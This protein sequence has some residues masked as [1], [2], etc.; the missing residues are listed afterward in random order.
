[1]MCVVLLSMTPR[2]VAPQGGARLVHGVV[3]DTTGQ[4]L[5]DARVAAIGSAFTATTDARG[6]FILNAPRTGN[7]ELQIRKIGFLGLTRPLRPDEG[8]Q[9]DPIRLTLHATPLPLAGLVI[10]G[11]R[12]VPLG[13]TVT[14]QS[15]RQ[16]PPLG[17]PDVM[18]ALPFVAG[19]SQPNDL[20]N[21]LHFAG[22]SADE[23]L[24]LLDGHPIQSL[25]HLSGVIGGFNVA[26]VDRAELLLHHVPVTTPSR[27]GGTLLLETRER[28]AIGGEAVASM[29]SS[30]VTTST[31]HRGVDVLASGRLTYLDALSRRL[32]G[33]TSAARDP[34][35]SYGDAMI[36]LGGELAEG[37]AELLSYFSRDWIGQRERGGARA[38]S[39][40]EGLVGARFVRERQHSRLSAR[41]SLDRMLVARASATVD[42]ADA[43]AL[44]QHWA[45]A[46]ITY[47]R[48]LTGALA[49][50]SLMGADSRVHRHRWSSS[51]DLAA[52][53]LPVRF[54]AS[55]RQTLL[56]TAHELRF[57]ARSTTASLGALVSSTGG[58]AF[59][60]PRF[61]V[62]AAGPG[63]TT[64]QF[65]LDRR[66]QFDSQAGAPLD[67]EVPPPFF[68]R[69]RPR[70]SDG[71]GVILE[72]TSRPF[73]ST[74]LHL[75]VTGFARTFSG[76]SVAL[77]APRDSVLRDA[78]EFDR[79]DGRAVGLS[80]GTTA[81]TGGGV[82]LQAQYTHA[83]TQERP[84][85][86]WIPAD[87]D[88]PHQL[89][90][91][92]SIPVPGRITLTTALQYR[93]GTPVTPVETAVWVPSSTSPGR[94]DRRLVLGAPNS[95]RLPAYHRLDIALRRTWS[96][97]RAQV[98]IALQAV[99]V[100]ARENV[101]AYDWN[102][103]LRQLEFG[104]RP[105]ASR[106]ATPL[107][108]S[109]G[110]EVHW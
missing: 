57:T 95:A 8:G 14:R 69:E 56:T 76:R 63:G 15:V 72:R 54:R 91:L 106:S 47:D 29:L 52:P 1:M 48:D 78:I 7:I 79:R 100:L 50:S 96:P 31:A 74:Q 86:R 68:L 36:R 45:S 60:A 87:W 75:S 71:L 25:G 70:R 105:R 22:A 30:G 103:Y 3:T 108:P 26:A 90:A 92:V 81:T 42:P 6:R 21:R 51:A 32:F 101:L 35:P 49:W 11:E 17:E 94:L 58:R 73:A 98:T 39:S 5:P 40:G 24:I 28:G 66:Y 10:P 65:A 55:D 53:E 80:I 44:D 13:Q 67:G 41:A 62:G 9:D 109:I 110:L 99:N 83:R 107:I 23:S 104:G 12:S 93:S 102:Q 46:A 64:W 2:Q 27:L 33:E 4:P 43:L 85:D 16:V 97:G 19:V 20:L 37:R 59:L 77:A 38:I 89:A 82:R 61:Q 34:I 18:R 88:A 84:A